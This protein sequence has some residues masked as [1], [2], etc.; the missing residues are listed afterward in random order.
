M[1]GV[2][3]CALPIFHRITTALDAET[4]LALALST[5]DET[6]VSRP[7]Q[8]VEVTGDEREAEGVYVII[9]QDRKS[10]GFLRMYRKIKGEDE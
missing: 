2:Q 3:T 7:P 6:G 5:P 1:T 10:K 9:G 8:L 4:S